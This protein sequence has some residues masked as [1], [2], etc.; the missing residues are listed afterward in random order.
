MA[1]RKQ[2]LEFKAN[3]IEDVMRQNRVDVQVTGAT[4]T[5]GFIRFKLAPAPTTRIRKVKSLEEELA[6]ALQER[7]ARVVRVDGDLQVELRR[8][9]APLVRLLDRKSVV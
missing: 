5:P 4:L 6:L 8:D 3:I 2:M 9:D 7:E 1:G